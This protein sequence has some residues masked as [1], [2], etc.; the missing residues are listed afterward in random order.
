MAVMFVVFT[1]CGLLVLH[2]GRQAGRQAVCYRLQQILMIRLLLNAAQRAEIKEEVGQHQAG[3]PGCAPPRL[4][5]RACPRAAS[6]DA[7]P[8]AAG[9]LPQTPRGADPTA[10]L[11]PRT[12]PSEPSRAE[13]SGRSRRQHSETIRSF[14]DPVGYLPRWGQGAPRSAGPAPRPGLILD[15]RAAPRVRSELRSRRGAQQQDASLTPFWGSGS[16]TR[17]CRPGW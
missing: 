12:V 10:A 1:C 17:W 8:P 16:Q 14:R 9:G 5:L 2:A 13:L 4:W 15:Q 6:V 3:S 7:C 11:P